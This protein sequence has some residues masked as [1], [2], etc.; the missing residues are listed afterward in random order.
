MAEPEP[1]VDL[2]MEAHDPE[3]GAE[4]T[5]RVSRITD[6]CAHVRGFH[7]HIRTKKELSAYD[8]G[9]EVREDAAM[10]SEPESDKNRLVDA[11]ADEGLLHLG[12]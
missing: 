2:S 4:M 1:E 11:A 3:V 6:C 10:S 9:R 7:W 12:S 5:A 8:E